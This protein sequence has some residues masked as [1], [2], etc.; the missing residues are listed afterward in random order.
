MAISG[1]YQKLREYTRLLQMPTF[2]Y[3]CPN[4]GF[5]VQ[6][7][8]ADDPA[9][10]DDDGYEAVTCPVC[11]RVHMVNPKTGKLLGEDGE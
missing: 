7:W 11:R 3:R 2:L 4:T 8:V 10:N 5:N 1:V 9:E 6:G